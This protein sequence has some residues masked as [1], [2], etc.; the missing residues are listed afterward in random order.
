VIVGPMY[1]GKTTELLSYLEIYK[2][3]KKKTLLFKP[4]L[5]VRYGTDVVKTHSG[6]EAQA[7]SVEFSKDMLPHLQEKIDAVFIDEVQFFDK[8]LIKVVRKASG[9]KRQRVL[10]RPRHDLQA[11]P[12]RNDHAFTRTRERSYQEEGCVSRL[13]GAQRDT[14]LQDI[15]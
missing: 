15:R 1:S 3:G 9:R 2:L 4:A 8:D 5:D 14:H 10:R 11:E 12:L 6:L 13:W 7:V